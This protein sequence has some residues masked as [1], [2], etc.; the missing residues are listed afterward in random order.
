[1]LGVLMEKALTTPEY[2]PM[3]LNA[4]VAACNQKSNRD[5]VVAYSAEQVGRVLGELMDMKLVVQILPEP[6]ARS[7]RFKHEADT[8]LGWNR[9]QR[10]VLAELFLRGPQTIGELRAR[11]NRMVQLPDQ[12]AVLSVVDELRATDPPTVVEL[13]R[14]SG[15]SARRFGHTLSAEQEAEPEAQPPATAADPAPVAAPRSVTGPQDLVAL[16]ER[17][18][19]LEA[20]VERLEERV[21][22]LSDAVHGRNAQTDA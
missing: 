14:Q 1:V 7:N 19:A 20:T 12:A 11:V 22:A 8:I 16:I 18:A 17:L 21:V 6:G 15:Q 3:T 2:Y 13:A 10:A 4:I 5:P 9:R